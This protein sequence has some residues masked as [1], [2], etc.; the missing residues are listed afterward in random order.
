MP[1]LSFEEEKFPCLYTW[2]RGLVLFVQDGSTFLNGNRRLIKQDDCTWCR[3][4]YWNILR[5][6]QSDLLVLFKSKMLLFL[7]TILTTW[8]IVSMT[9]PSLLWK[10]RLKKCSSTSTYIKLGLIKLIW[11]MKSLVVR[12]FRRLTALSISEKT[13]WTRMREVSWNDFSPPPPKCLF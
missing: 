3:I 2:N 9:Y 4:R 7:A 12:N 10:W 11:S 6:A 5:Q 13:L 8:R 1:R